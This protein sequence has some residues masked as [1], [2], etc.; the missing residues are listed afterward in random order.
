MSNVSLVSST[1]R[2]QQR[3][4]QDELDSLRAPVAEGSRLFLLSIESNTATDPQ[5]ALKD[6]EAAGISHLDVAI[7]NAGILPTPKPL[8]VVDVED[9]VTAFQINVI[10]PIRLYQ[11]AKPLLEKSASPKWVSVSNAGS[12]TTNL[13]IHNA[14]FVGA[15]AVSKGRP[16]LAH[17]LNGDGAAPNTVEESGSKTFELID[18]PTRE[19]TSRKFINVIDQGE[20]S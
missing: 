19:Q 2:D 1:Y 17:C 20:I 3:A 12:F 6:I 14:S 11:A 5:Q 16:K 7:A 13:D 8:D 4:R 9:E 10:G 15:Y 18:K